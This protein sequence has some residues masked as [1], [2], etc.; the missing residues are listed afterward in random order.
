MNHLTTTLF[1]GLILGTSIIGFGCDG[2]SAQS[3]TDGAAASK[4]PRV[5]AVNFP[6]Q[7]FAQTIGGSKVAVES[8]SLDGGS[9]INFDPTPE[10]IITIQD[11]VASCI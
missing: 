11:G 8:P 1:S 9:S 5:F 7:S 10:Q 2:L 6:L 4:P 3:P